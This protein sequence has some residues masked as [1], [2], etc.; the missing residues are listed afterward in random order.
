VFF[1]N[2]ARGFSLVHDQTKNIYIHLGEA[3]IGLYWNL[4]KSRI[5]LDKRREKEK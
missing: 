4:T 1:K 3:K 2:V 5:S